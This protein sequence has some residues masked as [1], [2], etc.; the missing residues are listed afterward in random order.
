[1]RKIYGIGETL[2]DII[3][4]NSQPQAAKPGG[5][6]LNSTVSLGRIGLPVYL[7]SEYADDDV[8]SMID[9]FLHENGVGTTYVD[10]YKD[11][12]TALAIA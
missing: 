11:G 7:I 9:N 2:L 6:M 12:K 1:M 3:F 5:A 4:K 10:H 8:G